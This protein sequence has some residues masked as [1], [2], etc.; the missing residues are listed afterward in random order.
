VPPETVVPPAA[1]ASRLAADTAKIQG[2]VDTT[3][4]AAPAPDP[5]PPPAPVRTAP[6]VRSDT[7]ELPAPELIDSPAR[8]PA[9]IR[10]ATRILGSDAESP[11]KRARAAAWLGSEALRRRDRVNARLYYQRAFDLYPD[12]NWATMIRN[13]RDTTRP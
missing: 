5:P 6:R 9:A 1:P 13:L 8:R 2:P 12:S 10:V 11:R 7:L 4:R 3:P